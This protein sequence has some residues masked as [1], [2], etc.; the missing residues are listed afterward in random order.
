MRGLALNG[1]LTVVGAEFVR[2][3]KTS[4]KYRMWS[5]D[6]SYPAMILDADGGASIE[7]EIWELSTEALMEVLRSEPPGLTMGKVYLYNGEWV[8][9][10]LGE[11][12]ICKGMQEIT[13]WGGF[14]NYLL[15]M[16]LTTKLEQAHSSNKKT[17]S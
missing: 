10:I 9:G 16:G 12:F 11:P 13:K 2:E 6:D 15:E 4:D 17:G 14:R 8:F 3:A 7:L 1:N 5:I